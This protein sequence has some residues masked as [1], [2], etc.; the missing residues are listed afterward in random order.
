MRLSSDLIHKSAQYLN[1]LNNFH[2]DLRGYKLPFIENLTATNDQFGTIDLT[3]NELSTLENLPQLLR[4]STL[5]LSNNRISKVEN[6]FAEMCPALENL[7]LSNNRIAKFEDLNRLSTCTTLIRLSLVGNVVTQLPNY[8]LYTI[9]KLP[10]L[11]QL[12]Y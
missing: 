3:D 7:V 12:D 5:L 11:R 1:P 6:N 8:R 4:L 2:L 9:F 10:S